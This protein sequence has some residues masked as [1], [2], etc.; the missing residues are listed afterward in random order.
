MSSALDKIDPA[1]INMAIEQAQYDSDITLTINTNKGD[2]S[3]TL[4]AQKVPKTVCNFLELAKA[5]YY[6]GLNFHRVIP[7]F[8]IQGG[9]PHGSGTGG[10]GYRFADEFHPDL[11]HDAP[12]ILSMANAGPNT[13]GSQFF[14]THVETPW[15]DNNHT[16]FGKVN[17]ENDMEV[18][19]SIRQGDVINSILIHE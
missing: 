8:M 14:I 12:G 15:L 7:D 19:N 17:T 4:F 9:C 18:V 6:D 16:V 10:P 13:N 1:L 2:I 11:R 5:G 3:L